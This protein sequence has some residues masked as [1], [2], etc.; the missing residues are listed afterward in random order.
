MSV[1]TPA[2]EL[3]ARRHGVRDGL[4]AL[5]RNWSGLIGAL[6]TGVFVVVGIAGIVIWRTPS[7]QHLYTSQD[8]FHT[9]APPLS[10]GHPLGTDNFGEDQ[11]WRIVVGVGISLYIGVLV[12]GISVVAGMTIG[13]VA[14]YVGGKVDMLL[15]ALIDIVWGFPL[16]LFAIIVVGILQPGLTAVVVAVAVVNWAG[17]ARIIRAETVTLKQQNFIE[18]ARALGVGKAKVIWRHILPNTISSTLVMSSYYIAQTVIVEAGLAF[19]GLGAQFPTPSLGQLIK[20]GTDYMPVD[21]WLPIIPG[22]VIVLIVLGLNL[23]GDGLRD[24]FDPR[25][26]RSS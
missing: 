9:L 26:H 13:A 12:T 21:V 19:V 2:L 14:G 22:I 25:L 17:F 23:L 7:L 15:R 3:G 20:N 16:L 6:L 1:A 24:I 10:A 18:A 8:L 5:R 4:L 11:A